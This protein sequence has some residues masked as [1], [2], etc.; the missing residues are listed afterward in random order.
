[1]A[2]VSGAWFHLLWAVPCPQPTFFLPFIRHTYSPLTHTHTKATNLPLRT[3]A[4]ALYGSLW[5]LTLCPPRPGSSPS[6]PPWYSKEKHFLM[7]VKI[8]W[9]TAPASQGTDNWAVSERESNVLRLFFKGEVQETCRNGNN[10]NKKKL[11]IQLK[12]LN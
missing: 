2:T 5:N 4:Y 10:K 6:C 8:A 1:M 12:I 3:P 7:Q 11:Y 9:T